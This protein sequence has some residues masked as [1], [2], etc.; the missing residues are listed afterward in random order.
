MG[1]TIRHRRLPTDKLDGLTEELGFT[2]Y[3]EGNKSMV[4]VFFICAAL[5]VGTAG[6]PHT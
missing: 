6:L 2:A 1:S 3:T 5:M 4:D